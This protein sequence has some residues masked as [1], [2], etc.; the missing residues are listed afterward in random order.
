MF[1][2]RAIA[3][4]VAIGL[5]GTSIYA[6]VFYRYRQ[7]QLENWAHFRPV[8]ASVDLSR[9]NTF[10]V[11]FRQVWSGSHAEGLFLSVPDKS[12]F[13]VAENLLKGVHA[14]FVVTDAIG[15]QMLKEQIR[16]G[17]DW[18]DEEGALVS[19]FHPFA[20]GEYRASLTVI[21]GAPALAELPQSLYAKYQLCAIESL[22]LLIA[23]VVAVFAGVSGII[24]LVVVVRGYWKYGI[25]PPVA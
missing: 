20:V 10:E 8:T 16:G 25:R 14:E 18:F 13:E 5:L 22:P 9:P 15:K 21:S 3:S 6:A 2:R 1:V 12:S 19:R 4:I 7:R 11:P 24:T 17:T 23:A